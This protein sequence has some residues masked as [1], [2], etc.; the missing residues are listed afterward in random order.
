MRRSVLLLC[1]ASACDPGTGP[2]VP[3]RL[4]VSPDSLNFEALAVTAGLAATV[5]DRGG[6]VIAD[7]AVAW[8]SSGPPVATVDPAGLVT[9]AGN[10]SAYVV[11]IAGDAR[12]SARVAVRQRPVSLRISPARP[13]RIEALGD[14]VRLSADVLDPN[15][16]PITGAAVDWAAA[17]TTI[18][19]VDRQGLVTAAG[20][21]TTTIRATSGSLADSLSAEVEQVPAQVR[22]SPADDPLRFESLGDTVRLSAQVLDSNGHPVA[23]VSVTWSISDTT[24]A[25]VDRDGLVTARGNGTATASAS[26]QTVTG[27]ARV[28]VDQVPVVMEV[29]SAR[30]L[31]ATGD[32]IQVTAEAFDAGGSRIED[33]G[34][35]WTSSDTT[36][37]TVDQDGWVH[38]LE[39]GSV[40][41]TAT[42]KGLS[43]SA[44]LA[45]A[46]PDRTALLYL[47][48]SANGKLWTRSGNWGT[49]A[50]LAAWYGVHLDAR[51]RVD[52]LALS[53]NNLAGSIPPE[54]G[55]LTGLRHLHLEANLLTGELPPEIGRLENLQWLGLFGNYLD[56]RLPAEI[57]DLDQLR[58][59]D[60]SFNSFTGSIPTEITRLPHLWY[61]GLFFN[62]LSGGIP[63]EI[64]DFPSLRFLD[65]GYNRLT[66]P[67]PPEIGDLEKLE[68][69]LLHGI[70]TNPEEGNR[71][72]GTIPPEIGNL[73]NLRVL[74][75]GANLIE[76]PI[77]P[78]LGKLANLDSLGL[79]SNLLTSLPPELGELADLQYLSLYGNRLTGSIPV[80]IGELANL[81]TL[82]LGRGF[83]SGSNTLSG[84]IPAELAALARL[85]R[86]DLGGNRLTGPIPREFGRL[87]RLEF[88]EL[89]S[90]G[91]TGAI[92]AEMGNLTRLTRL[93]VCPNELSGAIPREIGRMRAL[94][95]LFLCS[96][97]LSGPLPSEI[98]N[99]G[100]LRHIHV[101]ANRLTG[102]LP[103]S[104][105]SLKR[106]LQ[107]H[108]P[109]NDGLCAP[110]TEEFEEWLESIPSSSDIY[111]ESESMYVNPTDT[112]AADP[113]GCLVTVATTRSATGR[114]LRDREGDIEGMAA[115]LGARAGAAVG[116]GPPATLA[117]SCGDRASPIV[118]PGS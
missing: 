78:E 5:F 2:A 69:L 55:K 9:A 96:N 34:F 45:V 49:D 56:G 28:E 99:L 104:M 52:S 109:R 87:G 103:A 101:G 35:V 23:G 105:L 22:I 39:E 118:A 1:L 92:P 85:E 88:L 94:Y 106:L 110:G 117:V 89:G 8:Q 80:E 65:L 17:D 10:G 84:S 59:L 37:A 11:A 50:P 72:T 51:G 67:I 19:T 100:N 7:A 102:E 26:A 73:S 98:G 81:H 13:L 15:G 64:G 116:M 90:N 31:L 18:L 115:R 86:L 108:W 75:L 111:C 66:G 68:G 21:G 77:P 12:D 107:F 93:A 53:L 43:A 27:T 114:S 40:R 16:R 20:N 25:T 42:L 63:P 58:I 38:A 82:L 46:T 57:G 97:S 6:K 30:D 62:E 32:S 47:F 91:L 61:V 70:D 36:V 44:T 54:I 95:Y 24:V 3:A 74:N 33:A 14:T 76:G 71:L 48:R 60:L 29:L 4:D 112:G 113:G 41:I 83:T 79:Y